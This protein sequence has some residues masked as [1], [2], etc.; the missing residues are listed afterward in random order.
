MF[1]LLSAAP[2]LLLAI[3]LPSNN[4]QHSQQAA[5][6]A[7]NTNILPKQTVHPITSH[8]MNC[9]VSDILRDI[10]AACG[11]TT[12]C[13]M[14]VDQ[15]PAYVSGPPLLPHQLQA[16]QWMREMWVQRRAAVLADQ[17]G[18]GKTASCIAYLSCL[19]NEFNVTRPVLI[20]APLS[21][22]RFW[23]GE[24][25]LVQLPGLLR[26]RHR[27]VFCVGFR[28]VLLLLTCDADM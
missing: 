8:P 1:L 9:T 27:C 12:A 23:E 19:I 7:V 17:Q 21:M 18:S 24:Q 4:C 16:L 13:C 10:S 22:L 25:A 15:Q 2:C 28:L 20:V 5:S 6:T 11:A 3:H 14:Q 26:I